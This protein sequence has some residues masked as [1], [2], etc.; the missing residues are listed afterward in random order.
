MTDYGELTLPPVWTGRNR[1][2]GRFLKGHVPASKG[3]KWNEFM[4][5][6]G[7]KRAMKGWKNL[8]LYRNKNHRSGLAGRCPKKVVA[9]TD[10]GRFIVFPFIGAAHEWLNQIVGRKCSRE[11]I[12]RCCRQ[13]EAKCVINKPWGKRTGKKSYNVNIDHRYQGYRWYF[14]TDNAWTTKIKAV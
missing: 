3:K 8:D 4:S 1:I 9:V 13:N 11:N 2:N 5:K 7:Q 10:E 12:G 6:R 14:E